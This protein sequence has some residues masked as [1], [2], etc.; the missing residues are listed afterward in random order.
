[1]GWG[2]ARLAW[3]QL[4]HLCSTSLSSS[5]W[6]AQPPGQMAPGQGPRA[7]A[8]A[9]KLGTGTIT[10]LQHSIRQKQVRRPRVEGWEIDSGWREL[11][12]HKG[13]QT[14]AAKTVGPLLQTIYRWQNWVQIQVQLF[15]SIMSL[16]S[17]KVLVNHECPRDPD[18]TVIQEM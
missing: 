1:M 9:K 18:L 10:F 7:Q 16:F 11:L 2:P 14:E 12:S 3:P 13:V 15:E 17:Q 4:T 8:E 6:L 5:S